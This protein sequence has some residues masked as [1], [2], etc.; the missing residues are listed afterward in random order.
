[1]TTSLRPL[2]AAAALLFAAACEAPDPAPPAGQPAAETAAGPSARV[3]LPAAQDTAPGQPEPPAADAPMQAVLDQLKALGA[4]PI[5][6]L[7]PAQARQQPSPADAVRQVL[8]QRGASTDPE[9]VGNVENRSI[10][11]PGGQIPVR[12]YTPQGNGPFPVILY[13]HGGGWVIADLDTYDASARALANAANAVVVSTHYRQ[14]PENKFPAAHED[15]WAAY[16]WTLQNAQQIGGDPRRVAV[17]G[18]SAGGN[19]ATNI[20]IR[21]RDEGVQLPVH[22]LLVYPV[23]GNDL[24]TPSY[25]ENTAAAPLG[26][27]GM[28]WFAEHTVRTPQDMEDPRINL[29][30]ANLQGL[31]PTTIIAAQ[32]DPLRSEGEALANQLRGAGVQVERRQWDGVTHEF[33]GM[34]AV[35]PKAREAVQFAGQRLRAAFA[36]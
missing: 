10:P 19:L 5:A 9:P 3:Q 1:M 12:I 13:I 26:R 25:R 27:P 29:L 11:G 8:E 16:Q 4:Q 36:R 17:A 18:E 22:Q 31:P 34:A 35:V 24:N 15:V 33:F 23:A 2:A 28:I 20:S 6:T 21:A 30:G 32:I 7:A 14:A